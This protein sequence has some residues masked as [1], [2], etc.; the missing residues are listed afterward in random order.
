MIIPYGHEHTT[1]RRLPWVTMTLMG[2]CL[3]AFLVTYAIPSDRNEEEALQRLQAVFEYL[4]E[5][6]YLSLDSSFEGQL[7]ER[8]SEEEMEQF[9]A[10]LEAVRQFGR[11]PP[12]SRIALEREQ[13]QLNRLVELFLSS[14]AS[15][16][17]GPFFTWGLVPA[18]IKVHSL[19]S[20]QFL[21]GGW[22]H[23]IGNMLFLFLAG[24]FVEDVW[25]RPIFAAF[26]LLAGAIAALMYALH[27]PGLDAPLIGASG[28]VAGLMGAFLVRYWSTKI[29]F[30]YWFF[31]VFRGTFMAPAWLMLPLWFLRELFF[32]QAWDV[33]SPGA[34]GG[35]VAHWAHVWG[36]AFGI[37][38][39]GGMKYYRVEERH[40]HQAIEAKITLL[41]NTAIEQA[42]EVS[43]RGQTTE[44]VRLLQR[45]LELHPANVDA[46]VALWNLA[47]PRDL[48]GKAAPHL[49]RAM[50][51]NA[52]S[53]D[54]TLVL[55]HWHEL[56]EA[57]PDAGVE[58]VLAA[59]V[60]EIL[61]EHGR[62]GDLDATL[63]LAA[64]GIGPDTPSGVLVRL[65]RIAAAAHAT[66][67][68]TIVGTALR[69]PDVPP[70]ARAE[71]ESLADLHPEVVSEEPTD[72][73]RDEGAPQEPT[74]VP[75]AP[76]IE[77]TLEVISVV[78]RK[79]GEDA[80]TIEVQ[81]GS[82][83]VALTQ[84]QAVAVGGV[85][86]DNERPFLVVDLML[87]GPWSER[88]RLRSLR[89]LSSSFDPRSLVGGPDAMQAFREFLDQ[90]IASSQAVPLPDPDTARGN[91]FRTFRSVEHYQ[92]EVLGV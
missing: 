79:L 22:L 51:L 80:L 13:E 36:F 54:P 15:L 5:H 78:P 92:R 87:D 91:P 29:K 52:R 75:V 73:V 47:L 24:P 16:R 74:P 27:Y 9:R 71:L 59:R 55:N 11:Q 67:A 39:A 77:R 57:V 34:G 65:A 20:Y 70:E 30:F 81:G 26:Y 48:A 10:F 42:M 45:E 83:R 31:V 41:D 38:V 68:P 6:P 35:G 76:E 44:A 25:G 7:S 50:R 1:V 63:A 72:A 69:H 33:M 84:I 17:E 58:P 37:V 2:L 23:L 18:D 89:V 28:S 32:A 46:A 4:A 8:V 40:I 12:D 86:R 14:I 66:A 49:L 90:L 64:A 43:S 82:R 53:D 21:H 60:A 3:V 85:R 56:L 88:R 62:H 19:I 61:H